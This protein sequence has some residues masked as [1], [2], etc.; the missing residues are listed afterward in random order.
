[1]GYK[2]VTAGTKTAR[3]KAARFIK[4]KTGSLGIEIVFEFKEPST[5]GMETLNWVG[6]LSE[7]AISN[8]MDTLVNVLGFNGDDSVDANGVLSNPNALDWRKELSIVVEL[9][10]YNGKSYPKIK[11][12]NN[13]GGSAYAN[14][15]PETIK[16]AIV[17]SGFKAAF[18][19]A[20]QQSKP[21]APTASAPLSPE[22]V[23]F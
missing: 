8:T 21:A 13:M 11:W 22:Q 1:M 15:A 9:E 3:A 2:D 7:K 19:A 4:A 23:P 5:E 14:I 10:E 20:K 12:V 18:L 6:W 17:A 16:G